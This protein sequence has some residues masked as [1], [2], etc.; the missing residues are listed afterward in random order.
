MTTTHYSAVIFIRYLCIYSAVV[1][2]SFIRFFMQAQIFRVAQNARSLCCLRTATC[3]TGH[4]LLRCAEASRDI[5]DGE[6]GRRKPPVDTTTT[7]SHWPSPRTISN[8]TTMEFISV[9]E[10]LINIPSSVDF[11]SVGG[12]QLRLLTQE[13][14]RGWGGGQPECKGLSS[15]HRPRWPRQRDIDMLE[16]CVS[17]LIIKFSTHGRVRSLC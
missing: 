8:N 13:G 3:S 16:T 12:T 15:V 1:C 11:L 5:V 10:N 17:R 4:R 9:I 2:Y 14:V 6:M 7:T